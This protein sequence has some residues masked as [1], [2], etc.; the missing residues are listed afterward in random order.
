MASGGLPGTRDTEALADLRA[1]LT[2]DF[3][4][5]DVGAAR[6]ILR[7][8]GLAKPPAGL[9]LDRLP[10]RG[11]AHSVRHTGAHPLFSP[12]YYLAAHPDIATAGAPAWLH[13]QVFGRAEGRSPHPFIDVAW[14]RDA[15]PDAPFGGE[16]DRYLSDRSAWFIEPG[17]YTEAARFALSGQWSGDEAPLAEIVRAHP[18][19]PWVHERLMVVDL[20]GEA[21]TARLA[22]FATVLGAA[23]TG[24]RTPSLAVWT[25]ADEG[26]LADPAGPY[27]VVP[28]FFA[29]AGNRR[30]WW[31]G[32][33]AI[34]PDRTAAATADEVVTV[35]SGS[36][37]TGS[38]LV[39]FTSYEGRTDLDATVRD[40]V[41]RTVFA[42]SS[43]AVEVSLRQ[44]RRDLGRPDLTVLTHGTQT[45][46]E[47][48]RLDV[49]PPRAVP[50]PG[51]SAA[52]LAVD[53]GSTAI[54]LPVEQRLRANADPRVRAALTAGAALCLIDAHGLNSWLPVIQSRARV[55]IA[56]GLAD[57]VGAFVPE[58]RIQSLDGGSR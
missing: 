17:P 26:D 29:G 7:R 14:L 8:H 16:V 12:G 33:T 48:E 40:A 9:L 50:A 37:V 54:V 45:T 36:R 11:A 38:V 10:G 52:D 35:A 55:V 31:A 6:H 41:P 39:L 56:P 49:R 15:L 24:V 51:P 42:P 44:L 13:Y 19:E 23:P 20:S 53:A 5:F 43:R 30:L 2:R 46:V 27:L 28:G 1:R 4:V 47:A 25:T 3:P 32:D 34:S 22:A 18:R 57:S 58:D 21:A